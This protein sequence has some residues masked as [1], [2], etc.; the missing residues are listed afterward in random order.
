M[1]DIYRASESVTIWLGK[2]PQLL[3]RGVAR[4]EAAQG[5]L[6]LM[7]EE[8]ERSGKKQMLGDDSE[9]YAF[10]GAAYL[11]SR[12]WFGRLWVLQEFCLARRID[13]QFGEHHIRPETI[14]G[15]IQSFKDLLEG[16]RSGG[17]GKNEFGFAN[18]KLP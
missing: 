9:S 17:E 15:L 2:C 16:K 7:E 5:D 18:G 11:L 13:I 1:S 8:D 4:F 14:V 6:G 12:R 3:S 10:V